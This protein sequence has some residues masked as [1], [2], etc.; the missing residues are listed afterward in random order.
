MLAG[1]VSNRKTRFPAKRRS[2]SRA[3]LQADGEAME[4]PTDFLENLHRL[5]GKRL[6]CDLCDFGNCFNNILDCSPENTRVHFVCAALVRE[7]SQPVFQTG[8]QGSI[9]A[10][11]VTCS[12]EFRLCAGRWSHPPSGV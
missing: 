1:A 4:C 5:R 10:E 8:F 12:G 3:G 6:A 2:V 9:E 11:C 7:F